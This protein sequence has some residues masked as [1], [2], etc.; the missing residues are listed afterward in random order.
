MKIIE[1]IKSSIDNVTKYIIQIGDDYPNAGLIVELSHINKG[2]GK[3]I[4]CVPS[5]TGCSMGCKFCHATELCGK[6]IDN[7]LIADE[8][9]HAIDLVINDLDEIENT[10]LV[11]YMGMGDPL[12][13]ICEIIK[14]MDKA[15]LEYDSEYDGDFRE[16]RFGLCTMIPDKYKSAMEFLITHVKSVDYKVKLHVSLHTVS[17]LD[18]NTLMPNSVYHARMLDYLAKYMEETWMAGE[19]HYTLIDGVNNLSV[20]L[21]RLAELINDMK[22]TPTESKKHSLTLKFIDFNPVN[23]LTKSENDTIAVDYVKSM[24]G[25][26]CVVEFYTPP[27]RDIGASCGQFNKDVYLKYNSV[28]RHG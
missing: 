24:L 28:Y 14:S 21:D 20:D 5:R 6:V 15:Y 7:P 1:K 17:D 18:R 27:G 8:I 26:K 12:S 10:L 19:I 22:L 16:V 2:D 23:T 9:V 25:D 13:N 3:D 11:S 4:I